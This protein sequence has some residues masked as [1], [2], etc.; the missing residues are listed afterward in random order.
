[1]SKKPRTKEEWVQ[2]I[3]NKDKDENDCIIFRKTIRFNGK[4][5]TPARIIYETL[6]GSIPSDKIISRSCNSSNCCN[7]DHLSLDSRGNKLNLKPNNTLLSQSQID[8][9]VK[10][11]LEQK[12]IDEISSIL[13]FSKSTILKYVKHLPLSKER[14]TFLRKISED[15]KNLILRKKREALWAGT[16]KFKNLISSQNYS[17]NAKGNIAEAAIVYRL[18]LHNFSVFSSIFSGDS[19]DIIAYNNQSGKL[20]K[21]Q[22]KCTKR[23]KKC[24][25]PMI[26]IRKMKGHYDFIKYTKKELDILVGYDFLNDTAY[27]YT[28]KELINNKNLISVNPESREQ[29]KKLYDL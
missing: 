18:L 14:L 7:P 5:T 19:I 21:I 20:I 6:K 11:R 28:W 24:I 15:K 1:M 16:N 23:S 13:K 25:T 27:V 26:S 12:T 2:F 10:L 17:K 8:E 29:W 4:E 3:L 22:V 9:I